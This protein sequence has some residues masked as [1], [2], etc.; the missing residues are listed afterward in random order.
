MPA[1]ITIQKVLSILLRRIVFILAT[2]AVMGMLFFLYT[3]IIITPRY[4]T[5]AM[6]FIQNYDKAKAKTSSGSSSSASSNNSVDDNG[7]SNQGGSS[8]NNQQ[9]K[10]IF[11]SDI[12]GSSSL[13]KICV[14]LFQNS[15]EVTA[16]YNGCNVGM[17]VNE[18]TF[19]VTISVDGNDPQKCATVA[20]Q[21]SEKCID[22]Y[23]KYF[24]YG[25]I[26]IIRTAKEPA[27]PYSPN[28]MQNTLIGVAVGLA[29]ACIISVML[30]LIDTTIK[31]DEDLSEL[32]KIPVFAEIPDFDS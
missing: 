29:I 16:L 24:D 27:A 4:S 20:N 5:S 23:A 2:G 8:S 10:K 3:S 30:E 12:S 9:A 26:G 14:T 28:K 25:Q 13:A 18:N 7:G 19:Y 31:P 32:Y 11:S 6:I 1:N 22:V 15:D 21:I 17:T